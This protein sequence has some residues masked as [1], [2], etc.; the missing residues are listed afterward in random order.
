MFFLSILNNPTATFYGGKAM[1]KVFIVGCGAYMDSTYGCPGEWRCLKAAAIGSSKFQEPAQVIG[2]VRCVCPGRALIPNIQ[3]SIKL[4]EIV[5]DE[6]Y[7]SNCMA[8]AKIGCP[9][10]SIDKVVDLIKNDIK[11]PVVVG[12]H[13]YKVI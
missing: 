8:E 10:M 2:F 11:V 9:Y 1:K 3:M 7:I 4:S 13:D 12:T 5:P 6:I